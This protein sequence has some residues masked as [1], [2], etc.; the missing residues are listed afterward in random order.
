MSFYACF[1]RVLAIFAV[2]LGLTLAYPAEAATKSTPKTT[3][4][5]TT[6]KKTTVKKRVVKPAPKKKT[7]ASS[8]DADWPK[9]LALIKGHADPVGA[10]LLTWIYVTQTGFP[11]ETHQLLTFVRENPDWP[12]LHVFRQ[13]IE[14]GIVSELK[15]DEI[16]AWFDQN[17]PG[18]YNGAKAYVDALLK[19]G[20]EAKAREQ[21]AKFWTAA[22]LNKNQ[23]AA[24]AGAYKNGF[25]PGAHVARLDHMIWEDR[26]S[27]AEYMLAFVA[28]ELRAV[29]QAR[30]ALG[31]LSK[32]AEGLLKAVSAQY[33]SSEGVLFER[34]RWRRRKNMDAGAEE[35]LAQ[36]PAKTS[37]PDKWWG[38]I[39]ILVRRHIE[40]RD[41]KRAYEIASKHQL[42]HGFEYAQAEWLR[43]WLKL[44]FLNDPVQAYKHFDA[45]YKKVGTAISLSR[46]AYWA[47][48]AAEKAIPEKQH[49]SQWDKIAAQY[50]ST[51]YGQLSYERVY[52]KPKPDTFKEQP[53][54]PH[55]EAAFENT[56]LVRVVRLMH[57]LKMTRVIEPF[58]ARLIANAK[59]KDDYALVAKLARETGN[60]YYAVQANKD[61]QQTIGQFLFFEGY[62]TLPPLPLQTPEKSLVHAI[63]HRES[64]FNPE[65]L[66]PAGARGL[67]QLM[68]ATAKSVAKKVGEKY[69]S[70]R[71]MSDP[72]YNALLGSTY[73][74]DLV[75]NY[76][77]FYP[78]AIGAYNAGP[79]NVRSWTSEFGDPRAKGMGLIDWIEHI[80]IYETRNYIQ[81]VMESYYMYRL[82][83]G[84]EPKTVYDF[85]PQE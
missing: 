9:T 51:F 31:R 37:R 62:P 32:S 41:Y 67:M 12:K 83:F 18:S 78:M 26:Y 52:G 7:V 46:A 79:G 13:K 5:K 30:I 85:M 27:E 45:M 16:I 63:I 70:S 53:V 71:L 21:L 84:L 17:P 15:P 24:L 72:R 38:E 4:K 34:L 81:R 23:T 10:K 20:E 33:A 6:G 75:S 73:L 50:P 40:K 28:P 55:V 39:N 76:G 44:R 58:L 60:Y 25:A 3:A 43:G 74:H 80:P 54:A 64:M 69:N 49:A 56:S 8:M 68:P 47:A 11:V 57:T 1:A 22:D 35:I 42:E 2:L 77:G 29:A 19:K 59:V 14:D 61:C 36:M 65:A 66:S 82:R 48:R